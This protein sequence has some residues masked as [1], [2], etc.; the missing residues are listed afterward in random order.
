MLATSI[1]ATGVFFL[2]S[3][4]IVLVPLH[5]LE[6]CPFLWHLKHRPWST[7]SFFSASESLNLELSTLGLESF[8]GV[9]EEVDA[10][11][12]GVGFFWVVLV[13]LTF[14]LWSCSSQ[15]MRWVLS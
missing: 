6:L 13:S 12:D 2:T 11:V 15:R 10:W 3:A 4:Y 8:L 1:S 7:C 5:S 14:C 9:E